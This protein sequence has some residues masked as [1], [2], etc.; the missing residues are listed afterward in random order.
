VEEAI[1]VL[2]NEYGRGKEKYLN[3]VSFS[4]MGWVWKMT[5][6][7]RGTSG[8]LEILSFPQKQTKFQFPESIFFFNFGEYLESNFPVFEQNQKSIE[9][10]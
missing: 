4:L 5:R 3:D 7:R 8:R 6:G 9:F 2:R 10:T 1:I